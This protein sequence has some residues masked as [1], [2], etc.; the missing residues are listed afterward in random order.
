MGPRV[1]LSD[2]ELSLLRLA[3]RGYVEGVDGDYDD[4]HVAMDTLA[5]R[6]AAIQRRYRKADHVRV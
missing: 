1:T 4:D 3:L 5:D 6:L 2:R